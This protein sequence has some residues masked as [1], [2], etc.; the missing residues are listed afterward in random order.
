MKQYLDQIPHVNDNEMGVMVFR[1]SISSKYPSVL[2]MSINGENC[3]NINSQR[4]FSIPRTIQK[5]GLIVQFMFLPSTES[6]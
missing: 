3:N 1:F 5:I 4:P 2:F 6:F